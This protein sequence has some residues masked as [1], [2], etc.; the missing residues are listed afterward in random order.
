MSIYIITPLAH[1]VPAM[2]V[3]Q[4]LSQEGGLHLLRFLKHRSPDLF[5]VTQQLY[6]GKLSQLWEAVHVASGYCVALKRY[7]KKKLSTL[8]RLGQ[9]HASARPQSPYG[10]KPMK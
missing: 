7:N 6:Q 8:N 4:Y 2:S 9:W 5:E 3:L 10:C 1:K